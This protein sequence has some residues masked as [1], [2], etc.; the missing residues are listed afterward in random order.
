MGE[1]LNAAFA[2]ITWRR[3]LDTRNLYRGL[4]I[5][6][7]SKLS[8]SKS[9]AVNAQ[10]VVLVDD[11]N[12]ADGSLVHLPFRVGLTFECPW[13]YPGM[14]SDLFYKAFEYAIGLAL[15]N[16][17]GLD[18]AATEPTDHDGLATEDRAAQ[19]FQGDVDP[20]TNE[21]D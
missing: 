19:M 12:S 20:K 16:P 5:P 10:A 13:D 4:D 11:Y 14:S 21:L 7:V 6:S 15:S 2:N 9:H 17:Q 8:N 3:E 1:R 18:P